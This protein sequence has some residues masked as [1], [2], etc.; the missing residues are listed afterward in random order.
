MRRVDIQ[1]LI[2][3]ILE[4]DAKREF[5]SNYQMYL[6]HNYL[7][8]RNLFS[9]FGTGSLWRMVNEYQNNIKLLDNGIK[10]MHLEQLY[11][12]LASNLRFSSDEKT[13]KLILEAWTTVK[14]K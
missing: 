13:K 8:T 2:L 4:E 14:D 6:I 5:I 12:E 7:L 1:E 9:D 10:M 11:K 3:H